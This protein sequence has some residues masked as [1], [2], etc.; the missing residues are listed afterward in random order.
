M[1]QCRPKPV[2]KSGAMPHLIGRYL[3]YLGFPVVA[4]APLLLR[5]S[6]QTQGFAELRQHDFFLK[7]LNCQEPE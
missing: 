2:G 7:A 6:P 3:I 1:A 5:A 4:L